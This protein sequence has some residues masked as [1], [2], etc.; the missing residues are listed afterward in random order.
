M[1]NRK[2]VFVI[3]ILYLFGMELI[4]QSPTSDMKKSSWA[5]SIVE[6]LRLGDDTKWSIPGLEIK[7]N[8]SLGETFNMQIRGGYINMGKSDT[9]VFPLLVGLSFDVI[10]L[11]Q[12]TINPYFIT[13]PS[14]LIG[15]DYAGIFATGET[16]IELKPNDNGLA[17]FIGYGKNM[18]FHSDQTGYIKAGIGYQF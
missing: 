17:I 5:V 13:G 10:K 7:Y 9:R 1:K 14:L 18:L 3:T 12:F 4:A 15:S 16:G 6:T 8:L 2:I 11:N